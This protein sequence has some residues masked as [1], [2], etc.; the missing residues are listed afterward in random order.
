LA[1][2]GELAAYRE[3]A[4]ELFRVRKR[5]AAS[6]DAIL[7]LAGVSPD[8]GLDD[9]QLRQLID[10]FSSQPSL[11][12]RQRLDLA[13]L[14]YR[15]RDFN[16]ALEIL[17]QVD[18]TGPPE[19]NL[20]RALILRRLERTEEARRELETAVNT[21]LAALR[22]AVNSSEFALPWKPWSDFAR[23]EVLLAESR[24]E[25]GDVGI[26]IDPLRA[27]LTERANGQTSRDQ[28]LAVYAKDIQRTSLLHSAD[29][30]AKARRWADAAEDYRRLAELQPDDFEGWRR[31][32]DMY[33]QLRDW[34]RA[35]EALRRAV[36]L[37]PGH[38]N[39]WCSLQLAALLCA[40]DNMEAYQQWCDEL[41]SQANEPSPTASER[42]AKS[43]VLGRLRAES[44]A[45]AVAVAERAVTPEPNSDVSGWFFGT[46]ALAAYRAGDDAA[47]LQ[48]AQRSLEADN[49]SPIA[50]RAVVAHLVIA[51]AQQRLD[52]A[53]AAR[54]SRDRAAALIDEETQRY[55][56]A[57]EFDSD[58]HNWLI[59][60]Q[61]L[62]EA[63]RQP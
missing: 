29:Q 49:A 51:L 61:L 6:G 60:V 2:G 15:T 20:L 37:R 30:H 10:E 31:V 47:A 35:A 57:G 38:D 1:A 42:I 59:A 22:S 32:A 55:E 63:S 13:R 17:A 56:R 19:S 11:S 36:D 27:L 53:Q 28:L 26:E 62:R 41:L 54:A 33:V 43:C 21:Y 8:C 9:G 39:H 24:R 23:F 7:Q 58:W 25:V 18:A 44:L 12:P 46:R 14:H 40:S 3:L 48:W 16:R 50:M 52:D 45:A 4:K 5:D 34:G